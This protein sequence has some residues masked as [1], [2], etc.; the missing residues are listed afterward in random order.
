MGPLSQFDEWVQLGVKFVTC[1][2][3]VNVNY[4]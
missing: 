3:D 2:K 1:T 4:R